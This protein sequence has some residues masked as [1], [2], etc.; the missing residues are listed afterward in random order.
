MSAALLKHIPGITVHEP[1]VGVLA[2]TAPDG[3]HLTIANDNG[4]W[5]FRRGN[6]TTLAH[7]HLRELIDDALN[8]VH[9][10]KT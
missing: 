7:F 5:R 6:V 2:V 9:G 4:V 3:F 8:P 1:A 10:S